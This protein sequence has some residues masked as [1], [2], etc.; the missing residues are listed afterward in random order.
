[1]DEWVGVPIMRPVGCAAA[2]SR[3]VSSGRTMVGTR[4]LTRSLD[5]RDDAGGPADESF[6]GCLTRHLRQSGLS[7]SQLA[8]R[9]WLDVSYVSRLVHLPCDPLN[10]RRV[11]D[12]QRRQPSRDTV[13]RLGLAMQLS[14]EEMDELLLSAGY[15]P[16]VR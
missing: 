8:R 9:S 6:S 11:A 7:L 3:A 4:N 13:I 14:M 15:A 5:A 10:P 12:G 1:M 16:L 2:R